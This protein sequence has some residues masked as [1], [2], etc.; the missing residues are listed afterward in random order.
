M[1]N[2]HIH[3]FTPIYPADLFQLYSFLCDILKTFIC[4][5]RLV[6]MRILYMPLVRYTFTG[7]VVCIYLYIY[8]A[9]GIQHESYMP[10]FVALSQSKIQT[11]R[12]QKLLQVFVSA[13]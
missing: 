1:R 6:H 13:T 12:T 4:I 9:V 3:A 7:C 11:L 10:S 5:Y 8:V 2:A